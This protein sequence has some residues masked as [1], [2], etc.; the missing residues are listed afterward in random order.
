MLRTFFDGLTVTVFAMGIV[1][2]VLIVLMFIIMLQTFILKEKKD[3]GSADENKNIS[4]E[5]IELIEQN[6]SMPVKD[7]ISGEAEIAAAIVAAI[8]AY[9]NLSSSEFT[10][11]GIK[12]V[13]GNDSTWRNAGIIQ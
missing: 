5:K 1:F 4:A 11:K 3:N 12:R 8:C 13:N 6:Q 7:Q 2:A 10:I 9:T